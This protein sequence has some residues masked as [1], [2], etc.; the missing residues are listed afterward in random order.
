MQIPG[1]EAMKPPSQ[2]PFKKQ[3]TSKILGDAKIKKEKVHATEMAVVA[4]S[5]GAPSSSSTG[6]S[7]S[8]LGSD[9]SHVPSSSA[10]GPKDLQKGNITNKF[11]PIQDEEFEVDEPANKDR[12]ANASILVPGISIKKF[13]LGLEDE[14]DD[15]KP[16][17]KDTFIALLSCGEVRRYKMSRPILQRMAMG[18]AEATGEK[19][20]E[21]AGGHMRGNK[22]AAIFVTK[23]SNLILADAAGLQS[24]RLC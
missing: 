24:L 17:Q 9:N 2:P 5:G 21:A 4:A 8:S 12:Y 13:K 22:L 20:W 23:G 19:F 16:I 6:P 14:M 7:S 10:T 18:D 15:G 1:S 11:I 3:K